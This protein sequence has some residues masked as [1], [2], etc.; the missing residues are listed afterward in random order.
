[1]HL[2]S[3]LP[4]IRGPPNIP[5]FVAGALFVPDREVED[6]F[7]LVGADHRAPPVLLLRGRRRAVARPAR[8]DHVVRAAAAGRN[9]SI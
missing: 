8:R 3:T 7:G 6:R 2:F 1:M 5:Q 9:E 4:K